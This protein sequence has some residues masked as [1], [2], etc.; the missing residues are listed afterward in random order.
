MQKLLLVE[1]DPNLNFTIVTALEAQGYTVDAVSTTGEAMERWV[2]T[3][4]RGPPD[5]Y[6]ENAPGW[7]CWTP[8]SART[9]AAP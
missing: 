5:I 3:R 2:A 8:P 7:M 9:R 6:I 1:D 4:T